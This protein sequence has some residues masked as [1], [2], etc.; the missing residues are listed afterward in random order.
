MHMKNVRFILSDKIRSFRNSKAWTQER[1]AEEVDIHT[2]YISR[3]ESGKKLPT[4]NIICKIAQALGVN[5]YELLMEEEK[6]DSFD[7]KKRK[8]IN[9]LNESKSADV[10]IYCTLL[11]A[12]YERNKRGKR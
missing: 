9:I 10:D 12:L 4:L 2:T 1:L 11:N 6:V 5:T 3:I 7:H 8:M